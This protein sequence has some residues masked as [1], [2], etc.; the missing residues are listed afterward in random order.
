MS[1][2]TDAS[3]KSG[4]EPATSKNEQSAAIIEHG[5]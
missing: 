3:A 2:G 4:G 1:P 5:E